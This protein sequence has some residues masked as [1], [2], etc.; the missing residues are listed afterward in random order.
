LIDS[1]YFLSEKA[2]LGIQ[3]K[4]ER[5]Q[6]EGKGF[7]AQFIDF[8]K[9]CFTIPARYWKDGYDAL[10]KYSDTE[11]RRLTIQELKEIQS[12][13]DT[14]ILCGSNK[15]QIIQIGNA[16]PCKFAFHLGKHLIHLYSKCS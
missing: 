11:I 1:S 8:D 7:G 4:K 6:K 2:I 13:P 3:N 9:P 16:V 15:D 14:F 12:F 10:V 5:M